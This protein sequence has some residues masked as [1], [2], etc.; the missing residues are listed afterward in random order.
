[1]SSVGFLEVRQ[2]M[3]AYLTVDKRI[4]LRHF[5]FTTV[6]HGNVISNMWQCMCGNTWL[7][8]NTGSLRIIYQEV[9]SY[10]LYFTAIK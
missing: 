8:C 7:C 2:Y 1:M 10:P 4:S 3:F 5:C 9:S 6:I